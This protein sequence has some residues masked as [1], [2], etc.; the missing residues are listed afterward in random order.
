MGGDTL[1]FPWTLAAASC[2]MVFCNTC[3]ENLQRVWGSHTR[4]KPQLT[5]PQNAKVNRMLDSSHLTQRRQKKI[6]ALATFSSS[7]SPRMS[8]RSFFGSTTRSKLWLNWPSVSVS[9]FSSPNP[10]ALKWPET[11]HQQHVI[12]DQSHLSWG[13]PCLVF[14]WFPLK[15]SK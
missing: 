9:V 6:T 12:N 5:D 15:E 7:F 2:K 3:S 4:V 14:W 13:C 11:I 8:S 1:K 10:D